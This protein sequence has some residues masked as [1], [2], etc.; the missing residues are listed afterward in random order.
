MRII[1]LIAIAALTFSACKKDKSDKGSDSIL[2]RW[3]LRS[4]T[5]GIVG[6]MSYLPGNG[7][8]VKFTSTHF[9]LYR[10]D[11]LVIET[12]YT[13]MVATNPQ[14]GKNSNKITD[15][16]GYSFFAEV[17]AGRLY[18]YHATLAVDGTISIYAR[19][20]SVEGE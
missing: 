15:P 6:P 7:N 16:T 8:I 14:T 3:E 11:T 2:G 13:S 19:L 12:P 18:I 17:S 20:N 4:T 9:G 10:S 1:I 5:G